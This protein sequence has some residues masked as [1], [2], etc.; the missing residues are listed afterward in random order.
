MSS[1]PSP[2]FEVARRVVETLTARH[3]TIGVAE[4]LTGGL[5][6]AALVEVPGASAV[7]RGGVIAYDTRIKHSVLGVDAEVLAAH[8]PVHPDVALQMAVGVR[9]ALV[10]DGEEPWI[11]L[12]TTGVAGPDAQD[13]HPPGTAFIGLAIGNE[14]RFVELHAEGDRGTVRAAVVARALDL[15]VEFL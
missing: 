5:L 15:L 13:G 1:A 7:L 10:V 9:T 14:V 2:T 12:S 8:G 6:A 3:V 11:G 4:S